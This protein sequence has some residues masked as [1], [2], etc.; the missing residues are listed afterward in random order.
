MVMALSRVRGLCPSFFEL[1]SVNG[2]LSL[3]TFDVQC[4]SGGSLREVM[5]LL[6]QY[7][8]RYYYYLISCAMKKGD[9]AWCQC[10]STMAWTSIN[11]KHRLAKGV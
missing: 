2:W 3:S 4:A 1:L 5:Q 10:S 9:L 11:I 8:P 7:R 6:R